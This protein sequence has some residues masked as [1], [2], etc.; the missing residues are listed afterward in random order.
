LPTLDLTQE[1]RRAISVMGVDNV[2]MDAMGL[3]HY[4][5]LTK[6]N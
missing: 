2:Q 4:E 3:M 1:P 5:L 6:G